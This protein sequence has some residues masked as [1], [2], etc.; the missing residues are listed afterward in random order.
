MILVSYWATLR[1][2]LPK[3]LIVLM[4]R[5]VRIDP[6]CRAIRRVRRSRGSCIILISTPTHGNLGDQAIVFAQ[7][8]FLFDLGLDDQVIEISAEQYDEY[9]DYLSTYIEPDDI[10]V[11]DGGGNF[12]T[13]WPQVENKMR[14]IVSRFQKNRIVVFP[15]TMYYS[16]DEQGKLELNRSKIIYN[17]HPDIHL[18]AREIG[19][20]EAMKEAYPNADVIL[21][22]DIVLYVHDA[23]KRNTRRGALICFRSDQ[24]TVLTAEDRSYIEKRLNYFGISCSQTAMQAN[25]YI[26]QENR[27]REVRKKWVEFSGSELVVTD[28][29]HAM[30]FCAICGTPCIAF[31]NVSSKVL[32]VYYWLR[33]LPHIR[34]CDDIDFFDKALKEALDAGPR[35]Y[36]SNNLAPQFKK[37]EMK[38]LPLMK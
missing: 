35:E 26:N 34:F 25:V 20:Y 33:D 9:S 31:N 28:R 4:K 14:D 3:R 30:V 24:E 17:G 23:W 5:Y 21:A 10:I 1:P 11:I 7:R 2:L 22:P 6:I 38:F 12:G 18:C 19:S 27:E 32:G 16:S 36:D 29:L 13:L 15:N 8:T 37:I